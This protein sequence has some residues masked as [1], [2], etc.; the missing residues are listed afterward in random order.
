MRDPQCV[1]DARMLVRVNNEAAKECVH[2][3]QQRGTI[4]LF[5]GLNT[6]RMLFGALLLLLLHLL[7]R[8]GDLLL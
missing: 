1:C 3:V 7:K 5:A 2:F 6:L 8:A 4:D